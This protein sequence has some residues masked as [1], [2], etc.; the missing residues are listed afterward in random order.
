MN[1]FFNPIT[2]IPFLKHVIMDPKRIIRMSTQQLEKYRNKVFRKIV[3]Y[4]YTVPVYHQKYKAA[5]IHPE[6]IRGIK[7]IT[8]LPFIAKKDLVDNF[9]D[10]I[11]PP[12]YDK[13]KAVVV[14]T[15]G[16]TGRPVSVFFDYSVYSEGI[17]AS[18]RTSVIHNSNWIKA[19]FANIGNF[20]SGKADEAASRIFFKSAKFAYSSKKY[21]TF[22]AFEPIKEVMKKLDA[23]SPDVMLTYPVTYLNLALLKNKGFGKNVNPKFLVVSGYVLDDYTRSYVED[24]FKCKMFNGYGA[25]ETSSEAGIA[26][27]CPQNKWHINHDYFHVEAIDDS[28]EPVDLG[29]IGH[30][31]VTRLF[32]KGTPIIRYTGLDDWVKLT[33]YYGCGCGMCTPTFKDGI[34][35]RRNTSIILPDGRIFPSASFAILSVVLNKMKT[36]KVKQFQIIQNKLDDIEI[37]IVIDEELRNQDPQIDLLLEKIKEIYEEKVGPDIRITVKEVKEKDIKSEPNK[38]APLVISRLSQKELESIIEK[39]K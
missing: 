32:G 23:F 38:P 9:P 39:S 15:S 24:A 33:D 36:R 31:V 14:S 29:K 3:K 37:L 6:D 26:I 11:I 18:I 10:G 12:N 7:D 13:S 35:G 4:A 20:S 21:G 22:N 16:S 1:P 34:E 28:M 27:E 8:K 2:G 19:K 5:G 17:G 30:I 25:A